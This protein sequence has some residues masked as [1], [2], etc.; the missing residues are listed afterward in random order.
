MFE[1][2]E[3]MSY[4]EYKA[5]LG[6]YQARAENLLDEIRAKEVTVE[7]K[8]RMVRVT[9]GPFGQLTNVEISPYAMRRMSAEGLSAA[10]LATAQEAMGQA[11]QAVIDLVGLGLD[12][13]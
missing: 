3:S 6:Q 10:V 4:D 5:R 9:A 12:D 2:I 7:S 8:D 1:P 13:S 11:G